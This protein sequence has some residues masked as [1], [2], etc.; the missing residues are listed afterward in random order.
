MNFANKFTTEA[1]Y[2]SILAPPTIWFCKIQICF[3]NYVIDELYW[4][5]VSVDI[6]NYIRRLT[7]RFL[8]KNEWQ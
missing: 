1:N 6:V 5:A 2:F 8:R 3:L 4:L 7:E